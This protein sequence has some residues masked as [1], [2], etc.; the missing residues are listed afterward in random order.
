MLIQR[1]AGAVMAVVALTVPALADDLADISGLKLASAKP[2]AVQIAHG[3]QAIGPAGRASCGPMPDKVIQTGLQGHNAIRRK[4]WRPQIRANPVLSRLAADHAC[5][6]ARRG[7]ISHSDQRGRPIGVRAADMGYH[8]RV[9]GENLAAGAESIPDVMRAWQASPGHRANIM[10]RKM[11]E[12]GFG[13]ARSADGKTIYWAAV[14]ARP[15]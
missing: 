3:D 12:F 10:N 14:Y 2:L 6:M 1:I 8:W 9:I 5:D 7:T 11:R 13:W 4:F 15:G